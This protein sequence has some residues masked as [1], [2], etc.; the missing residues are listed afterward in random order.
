LKNFTINDLERFSGVKAHTL[1]I[2]ERRYSLLHP[3]RTPGNL[4][5]YTVDELK[6]LLNISLL[7][8]NGY[9]ISKLSK[10]QASEIDLNIGKLSNEYSKCQKAINELTI[11]MYTSEPASFEKVLDKL[12]L[13]WPV[14]ILV[15]KIIFPFLNITGLLF[16]GKREFEQHLVVVAVRKKLILAIETTRQIST[17]TKTVLL[18]LPDSKQLDIGLLYCNFFLK[19]RGVQVLYLGTEIT[20]Q[21]L[22][23]V[24]QVHPPEYVF[25]YLPENHHYPLHILLEDMS[26]FA[27][28]SRLIIGG[29]TLDKVPVFKENLVQLN[30]TNALEYLIEHTQ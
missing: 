22:K 19:S 30:Y 29:Y 7:K 8:N 13:K 28:G 10:I 2:W 11:N 3:T 4:R 21:N 5:L 15:E 12:L 6:K 20:I 17:S 1:R 23:I 14:D 24:L 16:M 18:F 9:Q 27:P 26:A 25:T